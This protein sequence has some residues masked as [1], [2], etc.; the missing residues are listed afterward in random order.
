MASADFFHLRVMN[1][2][3]QT[4]LFTNRDSIC[5]SWKQN[6]SPCVHLKP[7]CDLTTWSNEISNVPKNPTTLISM[8]DKHNMDIAHE[9]WS[10]LSVLW[11][12]NFVRP[13]NHPKLQKWF[14]NVI[15]MTFVYIFTS[16]HIEFVFHIGSSWENALWR[17]ETNFWTFGTEFVPN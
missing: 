4:N 3:H 1:K 5:K 15:E 6:M 11:R 14:C 9:R 7:N 8:T 10:Y 2:C 16:G 17:E 12:S 13:I